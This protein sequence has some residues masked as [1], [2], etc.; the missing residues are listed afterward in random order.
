MGEKQHGHMQ[1]VGYELYCKMLSAALSRLKGEEIIDDFDTEIKLSSSAF[2]P[3]DY[4]ESENIK[5]SLYKE[6]GS[7]E[8]EEDAMKYEDGLID[9]FGDIPKSVDA[10][11]KISLL[12][13]KAHKCYITQINQKNANLNIEFYE[14]AKIDPAKLLEFVADNKDR[15]RVINNA[16][17]TSLICTLMQRG[18][19]K[20][21]DPLE[22]AA[23][24]ID[25][26]SKKV[27]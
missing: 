24:Y 12:R 22:A 1:Q 14:Q 8:D 25:E 17:S 9:R 26:L 27:L 18:K 21:M 6:I 19:K 5:L 3:N 13:S 7:L 20:M 11:I 4:V 16:G 10:L 15:I 23:G 2:I